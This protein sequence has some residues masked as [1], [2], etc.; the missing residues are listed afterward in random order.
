[1]RISSILPHM[2]AWASPESLTRAALLAESLDYDCAWVAE[3][4][5]YPVKPKSPYPGTPDGS[6]PEFYKRVFTPVET[7][8]YVAARTTRLKVGT[9]VL[10]MP[11]HNPID[12][13]RRLT[14]LDVLSGGRLKVGLGQGWSKDEYESAQASYKHLS[15]RSD[16]FVEVLKAVWSPDPV[17]FKGRFYQIPPS[18]LQPK[19]V[20][21]PRPPIYLAAYTPRALERVAKHAD[22]WLPTGV[23][24][25]GIGPMMGQVRQ[26]AEQ[27][28]RDPGSMQLVILGHVVITESPMGAGRPDFVGNL[29]EVHQDV[30][31]A[32]GLGTDELILNPVQSPRGDGE[33]SFLWMMEELRKLA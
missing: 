6:L 22:G 26:L 13:A 7:L 32:R 27:A 14:T 23:P 9:S 25:A 3:R 16:E 29:D 4:W 18:I 11:F 12:V 15:E 5:L 1:V 33:D 24:M 2:G 10:N 20:Q 19:P 28:G 31:T 17:E 21:R 30:E 8:T